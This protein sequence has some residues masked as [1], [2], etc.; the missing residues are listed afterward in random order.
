MPRSHK[1][2]RR[3]VPKHLVPNTL[4]MVLDNIVTLTPHQRAELLAPTQL[5]LEA[6]RTGRGDRAAWMNLA[7]AFNVAEVLTE[8]AIASDHGDTFRQAQAAL[9]AVHERVEA[10]GSFT[11]RGPELVALDDAVFLHDV[12]LQ[13]VSQGELQQAVETVKRR[14]SAALAGN[15]SPRAYVCTPG[16]LGRAPATTTQETPA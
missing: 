3:Y 10:G 2:R 9:A 14:V 7:D 13:H 8:L 6:F 4:G 16:L 5:A 12:Q 11:L 15:A 1:P